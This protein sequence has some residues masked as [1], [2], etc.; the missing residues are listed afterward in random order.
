MS[1]PGSQEYP[2]EL[3]LFFWLD[4]FFFCY[5]WFFFFISSYLL[6]KLTT[7]SVVFFVRFYLYLFFEI[8]LFSERETHTHTQRQRDRDRDRSWFSPATLWDQCLNSGGA[9]M[10]VP[11]SHFAV[12]CPLN[13]FNHMYLLWLCAC[14]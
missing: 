8:N 13:I 11:A 2:G 4:P 7:K 12:L 10:P 14:V 6:F 3:V 1:F 9:C 5:T